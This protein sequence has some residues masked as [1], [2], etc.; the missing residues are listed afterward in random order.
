MI[1][2]SSSIR[3]GPNRGSSMRRAHVC[4]GGSEVMG[5]AISMIAASGFSSRPGVI[6]AMSRDEKRSV[7]CAMAARSS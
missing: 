7:S 3:L 1:G 2:V 5:G 4:T 6:T